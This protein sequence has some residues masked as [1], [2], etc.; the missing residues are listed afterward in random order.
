MLTGKKITQQQKNK[1]KHP[2]TN[3][4]KQKNTQKLEKFLSQT[5]MVSA[6]ESVA[7]LCM[8]SYPN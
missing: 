3:K 5:E 6:G 1:K 7:R 8:K 2:K 4:H